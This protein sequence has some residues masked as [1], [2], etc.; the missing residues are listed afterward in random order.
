MT[1]ADFTTIL[2]VAILAGTFTYV[3]LAGTRWGQEFTRAVT[4]TKQHRLHDGWGQ[5]PA[6][7]MLIRLRVANIRSAPLSADTAELKRLVTTY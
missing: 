6:E 4:Y 7:Q 1:S 2:I 5:E 3:M